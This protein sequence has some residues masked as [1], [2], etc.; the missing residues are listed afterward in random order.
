MVSLS[1][2]S[3]GAFRKKSSHMKTQNELIE[4]NDLVSMRKM[5]LERYSY[6]KHFVVLFQKAA[7]LGY[8]YEYFDPTIN[9]MEDIEGFLIDH[10]FRTSQFA[11][12][13]ICEIW[14]QYGNN[15][16]TIFFDN[17]SGQVLYERDVYISRESLDVKKN[18]KFYVSAYVE[19]NGDVMR[20]YSI[21]E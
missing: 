21:R 18:E 12:E 16:F 11:G 4:Q 5:L 17:R 13:T 8:N 2:K 19:E 10:A 9:D 1:I 3:N 15:I 20:L 7:D 6:N 14:P